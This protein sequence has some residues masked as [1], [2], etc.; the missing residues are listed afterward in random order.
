MW[1]FRRWLKIFGWNVVLVMGG[2]LFW[3]VVYEFI[4]GFLVRLMCLFWVDFGSE[5]WLRSVEGV[6]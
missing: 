5:S 3:F 4:G 1:F 2:V 6:Y